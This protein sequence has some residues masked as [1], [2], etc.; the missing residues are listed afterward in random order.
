MLYPIVSGDFLVNC[1]ELLDELPGELPAVLELELLPPQP[2]ITTIAVTPSVAVIHAQPLRLIIVKASDL[3]MRECSGGTVA[4][5][6][7]LSAWTLTIIRVDGQ[8]I[9]LGLRDRG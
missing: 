5:A 9:R 4:T 3:V 1:P 8:Y 7:V 2:A 6:R